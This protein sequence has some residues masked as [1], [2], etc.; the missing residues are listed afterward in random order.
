MRFLENEREWARFR[1]AALQRFSTAQADLSVRNWPENLRFLHKFAVMWI[2]AAPRRS[3][4]LLRPV[5][6]FLPVGV[7]D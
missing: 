1:D 3:V 6:G 4:N 5:P 7:E 2:P